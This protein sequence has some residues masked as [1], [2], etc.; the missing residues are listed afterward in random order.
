[1][2]TSSNPHNTFKVTVPPV[3]GQD[4]SFGFTF[5]SA[6]PRPIVSPITFYNITTNLYISDSENYHGPASSI[7]HPGPLS[8]FSSKA[9]DPPMCL[10]WRLADLR[11]THATADPRVKAVL[12]RS[13]VRASP[14]QHHGIL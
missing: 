1:M 7:P 12:A 9:I 10:G 5:R 6:C 3:F 11:S 14:H 13:D 2:P 4:Q 8:Y